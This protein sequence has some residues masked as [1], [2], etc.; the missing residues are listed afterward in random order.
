MKISRFFSKKDISFNLEKFPNESKILLI[1][2]LSG[3]GKSYL[4]NIKKEEYNATPF[5]VEWLIHNKHVTEECKY[6][7]T[8]FLDKHE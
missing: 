2:G 5:Q 6:I 1:T 8:S 4:A 3:S 7:L